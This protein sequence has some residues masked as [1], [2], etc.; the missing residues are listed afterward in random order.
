MAAKKS[1]L[2]AAAIRGERP[3][4]FSGWDWPVTQEA[5]G[6][7][8]LGRPGAGTITRSRPHLKTKAQLDLP[9]RVI[10][11]NNYKVVDNN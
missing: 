11:S 1:F 10:V 9:R 7:R 4:T 3:G 2:G 6:C 8:P 5:G